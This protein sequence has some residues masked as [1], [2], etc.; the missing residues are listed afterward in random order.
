MLCKGNLHPD[1]AQEGVIDVALLAVPTKC[2]ALSPCV[3]SIADMARSLQGK[4]ANPG[5]V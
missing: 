3:T 5:S 1:Q 2:A 4:I